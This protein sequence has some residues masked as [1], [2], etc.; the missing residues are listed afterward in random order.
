MMKTQIKLIADMVRRR[1]PFDAATISAAANEIADEAPQIAQLFPAGSLVPPSNALPAV[2]SR[3]EKFE[4]LATQLQEKARVLS[5]EVNANAI[6]D[7]KQN[8]R[9][10]GRVC[11]ACHKDFRRKVDDDEG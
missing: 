9:Q 7:A 5:S 11:A 10:L 8:F 4:H 1:T 6:N 3:R 2:W